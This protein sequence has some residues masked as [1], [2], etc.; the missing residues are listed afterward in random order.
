[1]AKPSKYRVEYNKSKQEWEVFSYVEYLGKTFKNWVGSDK[2]KTG[3]EALIK[4]LSN[5]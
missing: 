2:T 5:R 1:M 3:A 4:K